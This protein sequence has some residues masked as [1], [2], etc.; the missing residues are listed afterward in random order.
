MLWHCTNNA[1]E[2]WDPAEAP[3]RVRARDKV[4]SSAKCYLVHWIMGAFGAFK[5]KLTEYSARNSGLE[6]SVTSQLL[7]P[8]PYVDCT[9]T[10]TSVA[11]QLTS[12][13]SS[14]QANQRLARLALAVMASPSPFAPRLQLINKS[15]NRNNCYDGYDWNTRTNIKIKFYSPLASPRRTCSLGWRVGHLLPQ[16]AIRKVLR[17]DPIICPLAWAILRHPPSTTTIHHHPQCEHPPILPLTKLAGAHSSSA[18]FPS[19]NL[20]YRY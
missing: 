19:A 8:A 5:Q 14:G 6:Y 13:R 2:C 1:A 10:G 7:H 15:A 17:P 9:K 11:P 20:V 18:V 12:S 4:P 3:R 16:V